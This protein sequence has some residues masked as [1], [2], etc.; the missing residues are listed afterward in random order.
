MSMGSLIGDIPYDERGR[1]IRKTLNKGLGDE[2]KDNLNLQW[3]DQS[4]KIYPT[5]SRIDPGEVV[6]SLKHYHEN[7]SFTGES[8]DLVL[9]NIFYS[10]GLELNYRLKKKG[11]KGINDQLLYILYHLS[12]DKIK[13]LP[14]LTKKSAKEFR[15]NLGLF[16]LRYTMGGLLLTA[17]GA[18]LMYFTFPVLLGLLVGI[19][20]ISLGIGSISLK[21][22]RYYKMLKELDV[23]ING[24]RYRRSIFPLVDLL[25]EELRNIV[26]KWSLKDDREYVLWDLRNISLLNEATI[27]PA[28]EVDCQMCEG[29]GFITKSYYKTRAYRTYSDD[30]PEGWIET[31]EVEV[32]Y[33]TEC[34]ACNGTG[35]FNLLSAVS[36]VND[37][38]NYSNYNV[39]WI[40]ENY[41]R[42][43]QLVKDMN[44]K[45]KIWNCKLGFC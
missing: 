13:S 7:M 10:S 22:N 23:T 1:F 42:L 33:Q 45:A 9:M 4:W 36:Y 38:I 18:M 27:D 28:R 39:T 21:L 41:P 40:R 43:I 15:S 44:E 31:E 12:V 34:P 6:N 30:H 5:T 17:I 16:P 19:G 32:Q 35:K 24:K 3:I 11:I 29:S 8:Y 26:N 25:G 2:W 37:L 14:A 20:L